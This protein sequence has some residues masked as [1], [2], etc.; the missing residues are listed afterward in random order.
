MKGCARHTVPVS[1]DIATLISSEI[2]AEGSTSNIAACCRAFVLTAPE[3]SK[4]ENIS[5]DYWTPYLPFAVSHKGHM[6][7]V[8][9]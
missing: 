5:K 2:C 9:P 3:K 1:L 6:T 4:K 8:L 7:L